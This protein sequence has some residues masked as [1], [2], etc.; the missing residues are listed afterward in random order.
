MS[1]IKTRL[2]I[3]RKARRLSGEELGQLLGVTQSTISQWES[4]RRK[5]KLSTLTRI[6]DALNVCLQWLITGQGQMERDKSLDA[7]RAAY[8]SKRPEIKRAEK[9]T[10]PFHKSAQAVKE[11][12][13][14]ASMEARDLAQRIR[15]IRREL[16]LSQAELA[17]KLDV[18]ASLISRWEKGDR[19]PDKLQLAALSRALEVHAQWLVTG[20]G[21]V[22]MT[23]HEI[24][25]EKLKAGELSGDFQPARLRWIPNLG[26]VPG[27]YP[28]APSVVPQHSTPVSADVM[29]HP[30]AFSLTVRG[31]S[32]APAIVDGDEV[33]CEPF[34]GRF[35]PPGATVIAMVAG[36]TT[37]KSYFKKGN[38]H[39][40][41]S[42]NGTVQPIPLREDD[43]I[44]AR[45]LLV[46][47]KP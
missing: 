44:V 36:E 23:E 8:E 15:L 30:R 46:I 43:Y 22:F 10:R 16:G 33:A 11:F 2:K 14:K 5:P 47:K 37:L 4:G 26:T 18:D 45:V 35:L 39:L 32:M 17:D 6:A 12:R 42:T 9:H 1:D 29:R 27:G 7:M 20:E 19:A 13:E 21:E 38:Q 3:A 24:L 25:V 40:L 41:V 28:Y 31:N 34:D